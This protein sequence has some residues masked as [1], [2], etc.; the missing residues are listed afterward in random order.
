VGER[1][2]I[3]HVTMT[4]IDRVLTSFSLLIVV[5]KPARNTL[6]VVCAV[7]SVLVQFCHC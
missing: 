7:I 6:V 3:M 4:F 1:A 5:H 2:V